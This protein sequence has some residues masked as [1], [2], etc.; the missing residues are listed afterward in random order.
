[1]FGNKPTNSLIDRVTAEAVER[2][3]GSAMDSGCVDEE[4]FKSL[5]AELFRYREIH[6]LGLWK[7]SRMVSV[8]DRFLSQAVDRST[9][10]RLLDEAR[11]RLL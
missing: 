10:K 1:M 7:T 5:L 3:V 9:K 6:E 2:Q 11:N 8:I 4:K